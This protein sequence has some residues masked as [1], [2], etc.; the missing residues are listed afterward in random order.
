V[1]AQEGLI[2]LTNPPL[3]TAATAR[4]QDVVAA[5]PEVAMSGELTWTAPNVLREV[6]RWQ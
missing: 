5:G 2:E 1:C 4:C 3:V 6:K